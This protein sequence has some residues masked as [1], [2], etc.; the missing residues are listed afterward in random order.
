MAIKKPLT[1]KQKAIRTCNLW[2]MTPSMKSS[3]I[4]SALRKMSM[5]WKPI[6]EC[7]KLAK[8]ER[9]EIHTWIIYHNPTKTMPDREVDVVSLNYYECAWCKKAVPEKTF[10]FKEKVFKHTQLWETKSFDIKFKNNLAVDHID[11]VVEIWK[12][13]N[14]HDVIDR[15]LEE[16]VNK[17]QLLCSDCHKEITNNE[18]KQR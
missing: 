11:P 12:D 16:D 3:M 9:R 13:V 1:E 14:W 15:L 17:L 2:T 8:I 6:Q 10:T 18:N 7:K 5:Y 4:K